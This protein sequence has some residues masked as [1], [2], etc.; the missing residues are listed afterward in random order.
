MTTLHPKEIKR[1]GNKIW[2]LED[3]KLTRGDALALSRHLKKTEEK[4]AR[5]TKGKDGYRVWWAKK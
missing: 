1:I 5:V 2:H 3:S 4:R